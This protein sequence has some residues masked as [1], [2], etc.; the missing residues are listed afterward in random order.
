VPDSFSDVLRVAAI[1]GAILLWSLLLWLLLRIVFLVLSG[2]H[3]L[4][5]F[6]A[7]PQ[8]PHVWQYEAK[9]VKVGAVRFRRS[10]RLAAQDDGLYI[11]LAGLLRFPSLRIPWQDIYGTRASHFYGRPSIRVHVGLPPITT[12]D[13][14]WD[15]FDAVFPIH[16][17]RPR[18]SRLF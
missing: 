14:P 16:W 1:F 15:L 7:A 3:S 4:A 2:W 10:V 11:G 8:G 13:F 18:N 5:R 9:T 12:L 17:D 6:Y